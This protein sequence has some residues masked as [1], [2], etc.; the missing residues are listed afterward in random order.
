MNHSLF[1]LLNPGFNSVFSIRLQWNSQCAGQRVVAKA[2]SP[3]CLACHAHGAG[4][5]SNNAETQVQIYWIVLKRVFLHINKTWNKCWI[6]FT[7]LAAKTSGHINQTT[8]MA[9]SKWTNVCCL[10]KWTLC[11]PHA[12]IS[13]QRLQLVS[14][15]WY[16]AWRCIVT[17]HK[18]TINF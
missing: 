12:E 2:H 3:H 5:T 4:S 1:H 14:E 15:V 7:T 6:S 10:T 11:W 9:L 13:N 16:D 17:T 18:F 8:K